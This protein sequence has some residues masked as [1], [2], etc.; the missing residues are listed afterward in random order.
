MVSPQRHPDETSHAIDPAQVS[1]AQPPPVVIGH[2]ELTQSKGH[3]NK[4]QSTKHC[5]TT[6]Q[7]DQSSET[8]LAISHLQCVRRPP[9]HL[10]YYICHAITYP[11]SADRKSVV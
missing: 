6:T 9:T 3:N 8:S 7:R 10:K 11:T 4:N 1:K 5:E 2:R